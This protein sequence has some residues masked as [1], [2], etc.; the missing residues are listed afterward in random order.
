MKKMALETVGCRLNQYDTERIAVRLGQYGFQ[1][2][3][4]HEPA[5]IYIINT[6]TVTGRADATCRNLI[7]RAARRNGDSPVVVVGCYVDSDGNRVAAL[8][9]VEIRD[10]RIGPVC[11][12]VML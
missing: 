8:D 3:A 11:R 4:F 6:C 12:D 1:R 10:R 7:S 9:G 2:V 5:D